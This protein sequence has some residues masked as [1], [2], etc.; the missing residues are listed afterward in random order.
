MDEADAANEHIE[1]ERNALLAHRKPSGPV[2]T[3]RCLNCGA[4][5]ARGLR[6]CDSACRDD[7]EKD[8]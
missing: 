2:A 1:R 8:Q 6:W 3:G 5:L 4:V 7:W